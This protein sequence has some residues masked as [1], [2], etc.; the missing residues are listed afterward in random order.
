MHWSAGDVHAEPRPCAASEGDLTCHQ[1]PPATY[2]CLTSMGS[3]IAS[4]TWMDCP[5]TYFLPE[6]APR[7]GTTGGTARRPPVSEQ[8][9]ERSVRVTRFVVQPAAQLGQA[10]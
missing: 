4:S 2:R 10:Q 9:L 7:R 5:S 8:L 6:E 1:R 3:P